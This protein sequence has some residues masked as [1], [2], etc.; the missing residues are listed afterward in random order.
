MSEIQQFTVV[1]NATHFG[2]YDHLQAWQ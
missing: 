1:N 2:V